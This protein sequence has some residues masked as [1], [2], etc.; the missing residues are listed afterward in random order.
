MKTKQQ[1]KKEARKV[2]MATGDEALRNSLYDVLFGIIDNLGVG[3]GDGVSI[4]DVFKL[5]GAYDSSIR[6]YLE[7][8]FEKVDL[9]AGAVDEEGNPID[10]NYAI[11]AK[12]GL[13]S[14]DFISAY[15]LNSGGSGGG[16][17]QR[18]DSTKDYSAD[19]DT[20][21]V[22]GAKVANEIKNIEARV[23]NLETNP[24]D[25]DKHLI[26]NHQVAEKVWNI[27]HNLGKMPSV[28]VITSDGV[29]VVGEVRYIDENSLTLTFGCEFSGKVI[30]N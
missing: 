17:Y 11:K 14:V 29:C 20:T 26:I 23:E 30:L 7:D 10:P 6:E 9:N 4:T 18:L 2:R 1:L 8:L 21:H 13:F 19:K 3:K 15:G 22:L 24:A 25:S 16:G 27:T 28:T 12:Y 5:L